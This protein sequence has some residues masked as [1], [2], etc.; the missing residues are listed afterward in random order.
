MQQHSAGTSLRMKH[1]SPSPTPTLL[2][3]R[4]LRVGA[5]KYS[6]SEACFDIEG[7][8]HPGPLSIEAYVL[9]VRSKVASNATT[10]TS[11]HTLAAM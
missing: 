8:F 11:R 2:L 10:D 6:S 5:Y 1:H 7:L 4:D 3:A 9:G